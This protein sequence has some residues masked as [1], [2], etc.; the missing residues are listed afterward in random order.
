MCLLSQGT[1][2]YGRVTG[3]SREKP[4]TCVHSQ[5]GLCL[6]DLGCQLVLLSL[7]IMKLGP[8]SLQAALSC[9]EEKQ[10]VPPNLP[11]PQME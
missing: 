10:G 4:H 7:D 1:T 9:R 11:G 6:P 3:K 8:R 5:H 2:E